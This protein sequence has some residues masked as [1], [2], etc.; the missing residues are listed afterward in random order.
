M[1]Y[2]DEKKEFEECIGRFFC[3]GDKLLRPLTSEEIKDIK[4]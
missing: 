4:K 2:E 1:L 3:N